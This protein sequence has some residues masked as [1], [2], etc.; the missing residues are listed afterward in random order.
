MERDAIEALHR[1]AD[2][3]P[4]LVGPDCPDCERP[5]VATYR[6]ARCGERF[7][8]PGRFRWYWQG[9]G[10]WHDADD[11]LAMLVEHAGS[12]DPPSVILPL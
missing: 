4:L 2:G 12:H 10:H 8:V 7:D 1:D 6:C 11:D 3:A 9:R 5:A